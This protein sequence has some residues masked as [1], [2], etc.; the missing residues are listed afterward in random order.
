M[1]ES[2][3]HNYSVDSHPK[4][5]RLW[6]AVILGSLTAFG[7]LSVDMY[8]PGLPDLAAG[9]NTQ[10]SSAQFTLTSF[11][12]GMAVGQ[13]VVGPMSDSRG[14]KGPLMAGLVIFAISSL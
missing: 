6:A 7:P 14:R 8:L 3:L 10:A 5:N 12:I 1:K 9:F 13:L 4:M 2:V 11:L